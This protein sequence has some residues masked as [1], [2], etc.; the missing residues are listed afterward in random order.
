[1]ACRGSANLKNFA[2]NLRFNLVPAD[3]LS[4][5][6]PNDG[7]VHEGFQE[8]SLGLWRELA[9][10]LDEYEVGGKDVVFT[11]HSLGGGKNL[12]LA[13]FMFFVSIVSLMPLNYTYI[14]YAATALL[15]SVHYNASTHNKPKPSVV[16]FGGPKLCNSPLALHLRNAALQ[17][18]NILHLV[19]GK[20]PILANNQQLWDSLGFENVGVEVECDPNSPLVYDEKPD[21]KSFAWNILDHCNYLGVFVGPRII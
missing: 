7:L 13:R 1:M 6:V 4:I 15:C 10:K 20:D 18:C 12:L 21:G 14:F 2:T 3:G 9:P 19:H 5:D 8:A 17:N 11:G 16:S